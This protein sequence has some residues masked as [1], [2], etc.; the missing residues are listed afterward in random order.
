MSPLS[1]SQVTVK[2]AATFFI[3]WCDENLVLDP[4]T[5]VSNYPA[6]PT[7]FE[8]RYVP[9]K[10]DC[11]CSSRRFSIP[12]KNLLISTYCR[13]RWHSLSRPM[14]LPIQNQ[15]KWILSFFVVSLFE[16]SSWN[17]LVNWSDYS[18]NLGSRLSENE[19]QQGHTGCSKYDT[20]PT[21]HW[22][23]LCGIHVAA[24]VTVVKKVASCRAS[25]NTRS[26]RRML[27]SKKE[28][29][30]ITR[31]NEYQKADQTT[32]RC[33]WFQQNMPS[34][35]CSSALYLPAGATHFILATAFTVR[36]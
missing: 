36:G 20:S 6:N 5:A 32:G 18:S 24:E 27:D 33:H 16:N 25:I 10:S 35:L 2:V 9:I 14:P 22:M 30:V 12:Y 29:Y 4:V 7:S 28:Y 31:Q 21:T 15:W 13:G 1:I 3:S 11:T 8:R 26:Y 19:V 34:S 17:T 23:I